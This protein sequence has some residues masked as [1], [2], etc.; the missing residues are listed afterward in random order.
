MNNSQ[1]ITDPFDNSEYLK[2]KF[3]I[4]KSPPVPNMINKVV[5]SA[6]INLIQMNGSKDNLKNK[7]IAHS[8]SME[9]HRDLNS[10]DLSSERQKKN[11]LKNLYQKYDNVHKKNGGNKGISSR[12]VLNS[13]Y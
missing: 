4:E 11:T 7:T 13:S 12:I 3:P 5:P 10:G 8:R 2:K 9:N 1:R 6:K